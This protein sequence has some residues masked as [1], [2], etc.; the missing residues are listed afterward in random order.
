MHKSSNEATR[1]QLQTRLE[2]FAREEGPG[3]WQQVKS[4]S[5][6]V[7]DAMFQQQGGAN[8]LPAYA[9]SCTD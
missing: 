4:E 6:S 5:L 3:D 1:R 2:A 9:P 8:W 7:S